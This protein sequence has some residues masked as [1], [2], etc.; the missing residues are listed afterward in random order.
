M[1]TLLHFWVVGKP[2]TKGSASGVIR[3]G[4]VQIF[5]DNPK[6]KGWQKEI[7]KVARSEWGTREPWRDGGFVV[8]VLFQFTR[9]KSRRGLDDVEHRVK[10]DVDKTLRVVLDALTGICYVDDSQVATVVVTKQW[11]PVGEQP[12]VRVKVQ[13][14]E[15]ER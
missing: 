9:P 5:N 7:T 3:N 11:A 6:A 2:E 12:G 10:P 1:L 14:R 8:S 4:R 13:L 15:G